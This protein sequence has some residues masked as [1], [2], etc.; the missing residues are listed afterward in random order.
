MVLSIIPYYYEF[1]KT[2]NLYKNLKTQRRIPQWRNFPLGHQDER[3]FY[4]QTR[5]RHL[6]MPPS[7]YYSNFSIRILRRAAKAAKP[8]LKLGKTLTRRPK[9]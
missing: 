4:F 1:V 3:G 2:A 9:T 5:R 6:Q 7:G 8:K